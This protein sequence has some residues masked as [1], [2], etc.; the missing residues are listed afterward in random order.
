MKLSKLWAMVFSVVKLSWGQ[1]I[2]GL[3]RKDFKQ[4]LSNDHIPVSYKHG[5]FNDYNDLRKIVKT[6]FEIKI[7]NWK[8]FVFYLPFFSWF[9][10]TDS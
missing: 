10:T 3:G 6:Q 7:T 1:S 9:M 4:S 2:K 5:R 8:G